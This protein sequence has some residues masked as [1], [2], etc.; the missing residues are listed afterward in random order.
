MSELQTVFQVIAFLVLGGLLLLIECV[1]PGFTV[2]GTL[3]L[4][5]LGMA[6]YWAFR[7]HLAT[8][9]LTVVASAALILFFVRIFPRTRLGQRLRLQLTQ[10]KEAGYHAGAATVRVGDAGEALTDLRPSGSARIGG[11]RVDVVTEGAFVAQGAR[12]VVMQM[13]GM[14]VVVREH[15]G[16]V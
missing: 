6:C 9:L 1:T 4:V 14:R 11:H 13:D 7:L 8:G 5:L 10:R 2:P 15:K 16:G 3:G 12:V